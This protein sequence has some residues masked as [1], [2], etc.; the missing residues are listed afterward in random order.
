MWCLYQVLLFSFVFCLR[1]QGQSQQSTEPNIS[2]TAGHPL[3]LKNA[4]IT[5][6]WHQWSQIFYDNYAT[7]MLSFEIKPRDTK[8]P[9][10]HLNLNHQHQHQ[11]VTPEFWNSVEKSWFN[12]QIHIWKQGEWNQ[13]RH[14]G[15]TEPYWILREFFKSNTQ[16]TVQ[17]MTSMTQ[18][19]NYGTSKYTS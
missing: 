18:R 15:L 1:I 9:V 3:R 16:H 7:R 14:A 2:G 5:P 12:V 17:S 19:W 4:L 11:R 10:R 13:F 8:H 6:R